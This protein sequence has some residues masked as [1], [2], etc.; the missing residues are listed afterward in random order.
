MLG[1]Y[2]FFEQILSF[3]I[4]NWKTIE[5]KAKHFDID[6]ALFEVK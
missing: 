2:H 6:S 3:R 1:I 4:F 5:G